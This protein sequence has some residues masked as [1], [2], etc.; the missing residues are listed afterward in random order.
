M[1]RPITRCSG[2]VRGAIF[3]RVQDPLPITAE[4]LDRSLGERFDAVALDCAHRIA[5]KTPRAEIRY[6]DLA[7]LSSLI[8]CRVCE[9]LVASRSAPMS[10][11][12]V[13][14]PQGIEA[15]AAQLGILKAG[16][17][18]VPLDPRHPIARLREVVQ[19]SD[20][21]LLI[22]NGR[23][24]DL[25]ASVIGDTG[26]VIDVEEA[27]ADGQGRT[28]LPGV[29][30]DSL[31]YIY[32]TSGSTGRPK[33]VVD[34]HRN[35]LHNVLRYTIQLDI[36]ADDRLTLL[37]S[38]AFSGAVSSTFCALLN[39]AMLCSYDLH[40]ER[41]D[42]LA[43]WLAESGMTVYHSVPA[44]FR[45]L[46]V[47]RREFSQLRIVRLEGDRALAQDAE[48]FR[49]HCPDDCTLANGFG[50]TET[51]I[52]RQFLMSHDT[53]VG[54]GL[55]PIGHAVPDVDAFVV[56]RAGNPLEDG[57]IGEIAVKSRY[58]A[59]GY[60]RDPGLT[61]QKFLP[62]PDEGAERV[63]RTGDLGRM[64]RD[65]CL[66]YHGRSDSLVKL[67]GQSVNVLEVERALLGVP[68]VLDAAVT[69]RMS[70][71]GELRLAAVVAAPLEATSAEV[72]AA[73]R[74]RLPE[75]M[76]PAEIVVRDS[77]PLTPFGKV[78]RGAIER[79]AANGGA[80]PCQL[81]IPARS[82]LEK[83]IARI[84]AGVLG[85]Q[86]VPVDVPFLDLGGDSLRAMQILIEVNQS[87]GV[88]MSPTEFFAL[89]TVA[90]Q[91]RFLEPLTTGAG[92]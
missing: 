88:R 13:L 52:A 9:E 91:A 27:Q 6:E 84:W 68:G 71:S 37:Q 65:G 79:L 17:C 55:L 26:A 67:R 44:L 66:E 87:M 40:E 15:V 28:A 72:R 54:D 42:R 63:Y 23:L 70:D 73:L 29:G 5:I 7:A 33:G 41:P 18:Y 60:W 77:L 3:A 89:P 51:G 38:P 2:G 21:G 64:R 10:P 47:G 14:L 20:V 53:E 61:A 39:G 56:D 49:A 32:Y 1:P 69:P 19:H 81:G 35:V 16:G 46:V 45:T 85:H 86:A 30:P 8:A 48:L 76:V 83:D 34:T 74:K 58:L 75:Y 78:D 92:S 43:D 11:V 62:A 24:A 82:E 59:V 50:T 22:T 25:A 80:L 36:R 31:A 90:R 57:Q 4:A 12:A